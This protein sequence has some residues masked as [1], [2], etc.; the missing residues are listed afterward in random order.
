MSLEISV[1]PYCK[2]TDEGFVFATWLKS[3]HEYS[4]HLHWV[5][6]QRF[7][8]HYHA[9]FER[10]ISPATVLVACN[11]EDSKQI[12][13]WICSDGEA[14]HYAYTKE[15]FRQAGVFARLLESAGK[16][17]LCSH[18]T[19]FNNLLCDK[20]GLRYMPSQRRVSNEAARG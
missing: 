12:Y 6:K 15:V 13:G 1:R 20:Y 11:P 10:L 5:G 9:E 16:P 8:S 19:P 17:W 3:L 2:E 18:W 7:F 14:L 4:R